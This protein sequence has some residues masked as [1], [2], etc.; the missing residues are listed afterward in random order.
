MTVYVGLREGEGGVQEGSSVSP[1]GP[2]AANPPRSISARSTGGCGQRSAA[3]LHAEDDMR[4][5]SELICVI[6]GVVGSFL[7]SSDCNGAS[8]Q[9]VRGADRPSAYRL[10]HAQ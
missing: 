9:S 2:R 4:V 1:D 10:I 6:T 8:I 7:F 3:E 5:M